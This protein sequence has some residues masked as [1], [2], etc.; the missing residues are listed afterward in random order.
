LG[1][2]GLAERESASPCFLV[3]AEELGGVDGESATGGDPGGDEADKDHG[4]DSAEQY[5]WVAGR[6][7]VDQCR[8]QATSEDA[9]HEAGERSRD[10][11]E[12]R[13]SQGGSD[14]LSAQG[15]EGDA[16]S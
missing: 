16:N 14:E 1:I 15:A 11:D 12:E 4:R 6:C 7:F 5:E 3:L 2:E 10:K 8:K 9:Q 13:S